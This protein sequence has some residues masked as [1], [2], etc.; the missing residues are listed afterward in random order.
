MSAFICSDLQFKIVSSFAADAL[1][2][3]PVTVANELK[4][5]NVKSVNFRYKE[6]T[7]L[8]KFTEKDF[9]DNEFVGRYSYADIVALCDCIYYQSCERPSDEWYASVG[10]SFLKMIQCHAQQQSKRHNMSKSNLWS[11]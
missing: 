5:E 8:I 2:A 10:F 4:R 9:S 6:K 3:C 1:G 7:R 11:I